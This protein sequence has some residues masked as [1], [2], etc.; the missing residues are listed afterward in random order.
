M[1]G[2]NMPPITIFV[3]WLTSTPR[4]TTKHLRRCSPS[5]STARALAWRMVCPIPPPARFIMVGALSNLLGPTT[6]KDQIQNS[7]GTATSLATGIQRYNSKH[8]KQRRLD[9][10]G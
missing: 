4:L 5:R 10:E 2:R 8:L 1:H 3:G 9:I 6:I 7:K